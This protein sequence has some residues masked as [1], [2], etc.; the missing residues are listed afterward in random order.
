MTEKK[1]NVHFYI[2]GVQACFIT[3]GCEK[4]IRVHAGQKQ[5]HKCPLG[6]VVP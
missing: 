1:I 5:S 2:Q 3:R 6:G 4:V